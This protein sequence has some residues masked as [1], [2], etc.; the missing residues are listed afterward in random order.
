MLC[1]RASCLVESSAARVPSVQCVGRRAAALC[2]SAT[3]VTHLGQETTPLL[4]SQRAPKSLLV[5]A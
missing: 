2:S 1:A 5:A 3:P 4:A